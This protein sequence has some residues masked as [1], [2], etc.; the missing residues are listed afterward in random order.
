MSGHISDWLDSLKTI[1]E[2]ATPDTIG[3]YGRA[4]VWDDDISKIAE[5]IN[6]TD[7]RHFG[8]EIQSLE[9]NPEAGVPTPDERIYNQRVTLRVCYCA[10]VTRWDTLKRI[11]EDAGKLVHSI[12]DATNRPA[13]SGNNRLWQY[14]A[15]PSPPQE[16]QP[17]TF[18]LDIEIQ[19]RYWRDWS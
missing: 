5:A 8:I 7:D 13:D 2:G 11:A 19:C 12:T 9:P 1:V 6:A 10:G 3:D 14:I 17:D 15:E 16:M 18:V 4:F